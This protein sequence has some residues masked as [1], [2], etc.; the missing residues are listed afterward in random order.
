MK[1][2]LIYHPNA[3]LIHNGELTRL[4]TYTGFTTRQGAIETIWKWESESNPKTDLFIISWIDVYKGI[5][6]VRMIHKFEYNAEHR[7][8]QYIEKKR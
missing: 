7:Y 6:K 1:N 8:Q 5:K 3:F 2:N 4:H